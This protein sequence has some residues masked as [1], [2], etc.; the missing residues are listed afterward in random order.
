MSLLILC[1]NVIIN[2]VLQDLYS[3]LDPAKAAFGFLEKSIIQSA[4]RATDLLAI[5]TLHSGTP[6]QNNTLLPVV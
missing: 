1:Y 2:T 4:H 5:L 6:D 3:V